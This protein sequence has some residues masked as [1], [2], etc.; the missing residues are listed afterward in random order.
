V[1]KVARAVVI[2]DVDVE[3]EHLRQHKDQFGLPGSAAIFCTHD[4]FNTEARYYVVT[5]P[6]LARHVRG[7]RLW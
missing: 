3:P 7:E 2:E 5:S 1:L 4:G 6:E